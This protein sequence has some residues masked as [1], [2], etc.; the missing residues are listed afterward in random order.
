MSCMNWKM[1]I[2]TKKNP[3]PS[4]EKIDLLFNNFVGEIISVMLN[5]DVEQTKQTETKIETLRSSISVNGYLIDMDDDFLYLGYE[6]STIAQAVKRDFI[7]HIEIADN[8]EELLIP[9]TFEDKSYN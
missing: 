8:L 6:P 1:K 2:M 9:E 3:K 5:K 7:V 4:T